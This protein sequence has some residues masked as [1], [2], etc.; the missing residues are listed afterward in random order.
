MQAGR[1]GTRPRRQ[2]ERQPPGLRAVR[3]APVPR[4]Y[5]PA[6]P[7]QSEESKTQPVTATRSHQG[8]SVRASGPGAPA[9]AS[10]GT[11]LCR[12]PLCS[13]HDACGLVRGKT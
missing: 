7:K 4:P 2:P 5:T 9:A 6:A 11:L 10:L 1:P 13:L 8:V 12:F 3:A